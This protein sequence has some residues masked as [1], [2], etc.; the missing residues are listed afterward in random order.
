MTAFPEHSG[1][2]LMVRR[3][4]AVAAV[5]A[6]CGAGLAQ[7]NKADDEQAKRERERK[8]EW[9]KMEEDWKAYFKETSELPDLAAKMGK[10]SGGLPTVEVGKDDPRAVRAAKQ[11]MN[12]EA[13]R[14]K[15]IQ[16]RIEGGSFTGASQYNQLSECVFGQYTAATLL[17]EDPEKLLPFAEAVVMS[18]MRAEDFNFMRVRRAVEEPQL[19][20]QLQ[21]ARCKAEAVVLKLREAIAARSQ[22]PAPA[23]IAPPADL[24]YQPVLIAS[25]PLPHATVGGYPAGPCQVRV[26]RRPLLGLL[27]GRR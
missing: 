16:T 5:L 4:L 26:V 27:S 25:C 9:K 2:R 3:W 7:E 18:L 8:E 19:L 20:P 10:G 24:E 15:L 11:A 12:A 13:E 14:Y 23:P 1:G 6:A 21:A 17:Y 22:P